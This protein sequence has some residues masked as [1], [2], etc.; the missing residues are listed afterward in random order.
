MPVLRAGL[1]LLWKTPT[2]K[3]DAWGTLVSSL[4]LELQKW[5]VLT[6]RY[7]KERENLMPGPPAWT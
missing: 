4:S 5:Y 2:R 7:N 6:V 3:T 1:F